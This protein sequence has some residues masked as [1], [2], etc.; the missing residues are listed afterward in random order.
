M[1]FPLCLITIF[2]YKL[3]FFYTQYHC[4][5]KQRRLNV[6]RNCISRVVIRVSCISS[7][8]RIL[9]KMYRM[10][11]DVYSLHQETSRIKST[12]QPP[13]I[14]L[15]SYTRSI[16]FANIARIILFLSQ[17]PCDM[18]YKISHKINRCEMRVCIR[19]ASNNKHMV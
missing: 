3:F 16:V 15:L 12:R 18:L 10:Y 7:T 11:E 5:I 9:Y 2:A 13:L 19:V 8:K 6:P 4:S 17:I 14:V 1:C